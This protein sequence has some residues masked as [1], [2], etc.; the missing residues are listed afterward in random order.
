MK[1]FAIF[2]GFIFFIISISFVIL[3]MRFRIGSNYFYDDEL[4]F[5]PSHANRKSYYFSFEIFS[6]SIFSFYFIDKI[7]KNDKTTKHSS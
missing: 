7:I 6:N 3:S 4:V 1:Y 5:L 2:L